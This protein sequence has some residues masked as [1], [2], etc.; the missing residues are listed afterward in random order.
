VSRC[1]SMH[2]AW[3]SG[4][5]ARMAS[6]SAGCAARMRHRPMHAPPTHA[7]SRHPCRQHLGGVGV[8]VGCWLAAVEA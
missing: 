4:R 7:R 2:A 6:S 1:G 8:G 5:G 3:A